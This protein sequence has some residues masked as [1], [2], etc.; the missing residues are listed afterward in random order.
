MKRKRAPTWIL[1]WKGGMIWKS[2]MPRTPPIKTPT[3]KKPK[4][5]LL[6][7][8]CLRSISPLPLWPLRKLA[9]RLKQRA[10]VSSKSIKLAKV[11]SQSKMP[12][13]PK[14]WYSGGVERRRFS[15]ILWRASCH[16]RLFGTNRWSRQILSTSLASISHPFRHESDW[17]I[18]LLMEGLSRAS[19]ILWRRL[20][21]PSLKRSSSTIQWTTGPAL[22]TQSSSSMAVPSSNTGQ[23]QMNFRTEKLLMP[24]N[25]CQLS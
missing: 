21:P 10:V 14:L 3:T 15:R 5:H 1:W 4:R 12:S 20:S 8:F 9:S 13:S 6:R 19:M 2:P 23:R 18:S 7:I 11:P 25:A 24:S 22:S 17:I 16:R